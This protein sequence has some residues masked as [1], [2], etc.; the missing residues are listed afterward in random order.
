MHVLDIN[1]QFFVWI[2]NSLSDRKQRVVVSGHTPDRANF[3]SRGP[4]DSV[5][6]PYFWYAVIPMILLVLKSRNSVMIQKYALVF[7]V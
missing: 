5:L 6:C 4:Q 2:K 3:P 1:G 7:F